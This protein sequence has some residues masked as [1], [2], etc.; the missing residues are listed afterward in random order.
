MSGPKAPRSAKLDYVPPTRPE[1]HQGWIN[2]YARGVQVVVE[3]L[4]QRELD[5]DTVLGDLGVAFMM[6]ANVAGTPDH[7]DVGW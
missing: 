6:P 4:D 7:N 2:G 5:Y 1:W 3:Y